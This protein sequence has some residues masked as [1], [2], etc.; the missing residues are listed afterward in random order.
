MIRV[1]HEVT[2]LP[3]SDLRQVLAVCR[4]RAPGHKLD[5]ELSP[6]EAEGLL[7]EL[8]AEGSGILNWILE[9][10]PLGVSEETYRNLEIERHVDGGRV[11]RFKE[12]DDD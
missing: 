4:E 8:R 2:G 10:R 5:E 9:R 1:L 6:A 12:S 3:K 11:C 7:T